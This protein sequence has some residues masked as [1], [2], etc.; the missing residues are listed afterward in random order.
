[1]NRGSAGELRTCLGTRC[2]EKVGVRRSENLECRTSNTRPSR[3]SILRGVLLVFQADG[4]SKISRATIVFP[5]PASNDDDESEENSGIGRA[6]PALGW[7]TY[8]GMADPGRARACAANEREWPCV[9]A[10]GNAWN[11]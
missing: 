2:E 9:H 8:L 5:K 7:D 1:M 3:G 10:T 4:S 6:W 11:A